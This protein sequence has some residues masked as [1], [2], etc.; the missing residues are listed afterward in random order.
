MTLT[1]SQLEE[2]AAFC[3]LTPSLEAA[4]EGAVRAFFGEPDE[5]PISYWPGVGNAAS[6]ERRFVAW[7][8]FTPLP[9][10]RRPVER[11][12]EELYTGA[13][14]A[15][16]LHAVQGARFVLAV[17]TA[18]KATSVILELENERFAVRSNL[19]AEAF[20]KDMA[21]VAHLVPA[22]QR[23]WL[24]GPGWFEW[25][26]RIGPGIRRELRQYQ[27][28]PIQVERF[29]QGHLESEQRAAPAIP[30]DATLEQAVARVTEAATRQGRA[31]LVLSVEE[32][33][34][35][36]WKYLRKADAAGFAREVMKRAEPTDSVDE[37]NRCLALAMNVW[38]ATPQPDRGGKAANELSS[39]TG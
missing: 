7:F 16:M 22:G 6:M 2:I 14:R 21:V 4:R 34:A 1:A 10:G 20:V 32:W 24:P 12:A 11:A 18:V 19:W 5:R 39:G 23:V 26:A 28:D 27:L 36:V 38:N 17:V 3:A 25:P 8:M 37:L 33:R 30:K 13:L 31:Q 29:L 9:D 35:L 15:E